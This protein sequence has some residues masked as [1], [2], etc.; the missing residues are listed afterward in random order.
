MKFDGL[1]SHDTN[2]IFQRNGSVHAPNILARKPEKD[3]LPQCKK[4][5]PNRRLTINRA[6]CQYQLVIHILDAF[7]MGTVNA[8]HA[9][10]S[11]KL[12]P[13]NIMS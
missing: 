10:L 7:D 6:P 8:K 3:T 2:C 9:A 1:H 11:N 13:R 4:T 12:Y 5:E